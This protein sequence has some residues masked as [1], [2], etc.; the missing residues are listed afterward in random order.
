MKVRRKIAAAALAGTSMI[1]LVSCGKE[2]E[3]EAQRVHMGVAYYDSGI[4]F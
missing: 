2:Q 1:F 3:Q 4:P